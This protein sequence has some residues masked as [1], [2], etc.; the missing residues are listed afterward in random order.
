[1]SGK[2]DILL[3]ELIMAMTKW[4][5]SDAHDELLEKLRMRSTDDLSVDV[6]EDDMNVYVAMHMPGIEKDKVGV[7]L[8]GRHLTVSG[9]RKDTEEFKNKKYVLKE[10]RRGY[11]TR[12][13]ELP[14][15]VDHD[16]TW[17]QLKEGALVIVCPKKK[18]GEKV[19]KVPVK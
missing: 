15:A 3:Q 11:F 19:T 9:Y 2:Y 13:I 8:E 12:V 6:S 5:S 16:Q 7:E 10:I 1:M 4:Q 14:C 18:Q 17:A